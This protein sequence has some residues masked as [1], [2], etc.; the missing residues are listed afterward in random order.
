MFGTVALLLLL[1]VFSVLSQN[2]CF[3]NT[4]GIGR[5]QERWFCRGHSHSV[6]DRC[7]NSQLYCCPLSHS[8]ERSVNAVSSPKFPTYCG[9]TPMYPIRNI[10]GGIR[11]EP[12]E[13]SWAARLQYGNRRSSGNCG[14]SVINSLYVLTAAHCVTGENT[15]KSR[16]V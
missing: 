3:T 4:Q 15:L 8:G 9:S 10:L 6:L 13:F 1:Q 2:I 14:G 7:A 16:G 5:C 11:I 12:D